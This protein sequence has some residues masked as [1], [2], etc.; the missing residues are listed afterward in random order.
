MKIFTLYCFCL[1][2]V[3]LFA[4]F[5][6]W[7][8]HILE[9]MPVPGSLYRYHQCVCVYY[10]KYVESILTF[11]LFD[12]YTQVVDQIHMSL[13]TH[14]DTP[15]TL[16]NGYIIKTLRN[17]MN[18]TASYINV[19]INSHIYIIHTRAAQAYILRFF[20]KPILVSY[21]KNSTESSKYKNTYAYKLLVCHIMP[22]IK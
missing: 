3:M 14:G 11:L 2:Y 20:F 9:A 16:Y 18:N 7:N 22:V 12:V 8:L 21:I 13:S 1:L 4:A 6:H 19:I 5:T 15:W 17:A 10:C